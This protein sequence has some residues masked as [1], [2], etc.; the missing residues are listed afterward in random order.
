MKEEE[1][2]SVWIRD[3]K[4]D[5]VMSYLMELAEKGVVHA[6]IGGPPCRTM[7]RLR[8]NQPGPPPLRSRSG[9][10][11]FGLDQ[12]SEW[13]R[14]QVRGDTVLWLRQLW[15]YMTAEEAS[16]RPVL[17][18]KEHPQDPQSYKDESDPI[19]YPSYFSWPEWK[20]FCQRH[21]VSEVTL[22]LGAYGHP[23]C[24][25]TTL[26][27]NIRGLLRL[28]GR[29]ADRTVRDETSFGAQ[30]ESLQERI[31]RSRTWAAWPESFKEE[32]V[33]ALKAELNDPEMRKMTPEQ[34]R[35]HIACDHQPF[36][37]ECTTCQKGAGRRVV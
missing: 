17:F 3:L 18:L 13:Q 37:R 19:D 35:R 21:Q 10:Q 5:A 15:L 6:V 8:F 12:L 22:D 26:G 30:E 29:R 28:H 33:S 4:S 1:P 16:G 25:P 23:R 14:E 9:P 36:S 34:W 31:Q 2:L 27:T 24:K 7:S 20:D 11:R 32:V